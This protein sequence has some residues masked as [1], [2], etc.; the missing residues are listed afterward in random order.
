MKNAVC[1]ALNT[2][3]VAN[4]MWLNK[5][6]LKGKLRASPEIGMRADLSGLRSKS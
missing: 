5:D 3:A 2:D 6:R 1:A 4:R